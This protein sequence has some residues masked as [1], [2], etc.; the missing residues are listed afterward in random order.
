MDTDAFAAAHR[1]DW[2]RLEELSRRRRL[3]GAEV[4]ELASLYRQGAAQLSRI[5]TQAPD[6][7]LISRLSTVL[8][9]ARA[10]LAP[11]RGLS[12]TQ[13]ASFFMVTLP[14]AFYRVRWWTIGVG[15]AFILIAVAAGWWFTQSPA[16][17]ASVGTPAQLQDYANQAFEAYYSN[18]PAPDF[19]AQVWTNNAWISFQAVGGGIT[20]FWPVFLLWQNAV[21]VGQAGGIMAVYGDVGVF[22]GLILPHGLM[23]LTAIFIAIGAGLKIFWTAIVPG[24]RTRIR[25]LR[26]EGTRLI[27]VALGLVAV[28]GV[29]AV[30]EAFVTPSG[31]PGW[32]K[33][34]IGALVLVAYWVY[35]LVLGRKAVE[36]GESSDIAEERGGYVVLEAA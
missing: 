7:A 2:H 15:L 35:T 31:M 24:S 19:A 6:P 17:Q 30:V 18:Y 28:L 8:G 3:N 1:A 20:G 13:I 12:A 32:L 36:R 33:I 9:E 25:A 10:R 16:V 34:T 29:S 11:Q 4:D 5:R 27:V 22:F 14:A 23:E 21:A 26:E